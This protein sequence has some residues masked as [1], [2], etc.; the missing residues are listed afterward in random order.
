MS[1]LEKQLQARAAGLRSVG[2]PPETKAAA[3]AGETNALAGALMAAL[4]QHRKD[5]EGDDGDDG[6]G[7]EGGDDWE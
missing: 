7:D 5:I 2:P 4:K 6:W 1:D 3:P